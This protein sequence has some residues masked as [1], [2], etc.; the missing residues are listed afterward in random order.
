MTKSIEE[1]S[2]VLDSIS[3]V[4]TNADQ[5]DLLDKTIK[6]IADVD[7]PLQ[8]I[9]PLLRIFERF[10]EA[11][12]FGVFWSILHRIEATPGF[13]PFLLASVKRKPSEFTVMII[14]RMINGG[15]TD[16]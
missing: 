14:N 4:S 8:A 12:G 9:Q 1:I 16:K 10:P 2:K 6:D 7:Q 13:E 15:I 3:D 11:D 5:L